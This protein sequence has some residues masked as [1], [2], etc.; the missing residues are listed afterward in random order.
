MR[1]YSG[2]SQQFIEDTVR[3]QIA[4]KLKLAFFDH[5]RYEPPES[6]VRSWQNSLR[7]MGSMVEHSSL[8]DH[9][10]LLEYQLPLS[11]R[12]LDCLLAGHDGDGQP[13]AVVV[14]LKQWEGCEDAEGEN[15]VITWLGGG[16][17]EVL[18]PSVQVDRYRM[19][20][21]DTHPAFYEDPDPVALHAC[22]YL[23]NHNPETGDPLFAPK[24]EPILATSPAFTADDFDVMSSFLRQRLEGGQGLAV[25]P[26]VEE[27]RY[28]PSKKLMDHVGHVIK[29]N[30]EYVLLDEQLVVYDKVLARARRGFHGRKATALL[31]R[32]GPGTGKSVIALNLMADLLLKGYNAHYATG[33]RAFTGT[34]RKI[35]GPRGG[36]QFKYFNSYQGAEPNAV[37]VLIC[38]E[39]HRIRE[40]SHSRFTPKADRTGLPQIGELLDAGKVGVFFVD[41]LQVVRPGEIGS[42]AYIR[43]EAEKRDCEVLEYEL[44]A[45]FRCAGS[46]AFVNWVNNT[47]GVAR[48]AT[49]LWEGNENF[50]FRIFPDPQSLEEA[51]RRRANE[52]NTARLTAGFC[53]PWSKKPLADGTLENDVQIGSYQRP[54]NARPEATRLASGI[55]K[56][57]LWAH[58]SGGLDQ[59][60][61]VYTAQGFEFD[62]VGVILG[63]DLRYDFDSQAWIGDKLESGDP[64]VKRAK[65]FADLIKN[66]YRVLLSRGMKGCYVYFQDKDT[67]RF[68]RSRME[69]ALVEMVAEPE[70]A[71]GEEPTQE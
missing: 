9:G 60:G 25:L 22:A 65:N 3:N 4:G 49:V 71:Y 55:P 32:G 66:T 1:L 67:E 61:C 53:W 41:D 50:D 21:E 15:E 68:F 20:L 6:E 24:F 33:S 56:A 59:I 36:I 54:W 52:G 10:V 16:E 13:S 17:R 38:D 45:Q 58:E 19:Y 8:L 42:S 43:E 39:S 44:E 70:S 63:R 28:R 69:T 2:S 11:S 48:T 27:N 26:R 23:H 51:I 47:L 18:H 30:S 37:D 29:G 40:T 5:F 12:R 64:V 31:V 62:Y 34:L 57:N 46:D 14:E 7:A 35:I